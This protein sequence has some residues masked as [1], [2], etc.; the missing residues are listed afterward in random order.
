MLYW[1]PELEHYLTGYI[2]K[3]SSKLNMNNELFFFLKQPLKNYY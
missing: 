2:A 3:Y 1:R